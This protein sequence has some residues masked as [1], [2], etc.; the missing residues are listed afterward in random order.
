L[1]LHENTLLQNQALTKIQ[2]QLDLSN[3]ES[4]EKLRSLYELSP[5]GIALTDMNGHYIEFNE[6]FRR[7]CGYPEDELKVLDYW[8][9]TPKQYE[10]EEWCQLES[11]AKTGHYGPYEKEY[12]RKDG[13]RVP[14]CLNGLSV[15]GHD[16]KKYIW[17]IVE[18]ITERKLAETQVNQRAEMALHASLI[19]YHLLFE[20][21]RDAL[22]MLDPVSLKFTEANQATLDM[23]RVPSIAEF[24]KLGPP[25]V[26]P[27]RQPDDQLS[28]PQAKKIIESVLQE[29][30]R[31]F[32]W[33][34]QRTDGELF[35]ADVMLTRMEDEGKVFLMATVRDITERKQTETALQKEKDEQTLL[36]NKLEEVQ[37]H[38]M[39]SEK[40]ASIGLLAAGV[41]HEINNP[42]GY[43]YS[44]LGTLEKYAQDA[45]GLLALYEQA[46]DSISDAQVCESLKKAK[47]KLDIAFLKEDLSALIAESRNGITRVKDIVQN[48]KDFSHVDAA[49]VW[50]FSDLHRGM[51]S[52]LNIVNN[53]IKYKAD[54]V[55]EYGVIPEVECIS[56]Q[57]NQVFMNIL[58]NAAHA[59]DQHGTITIRTGQED[60]NIWVEI[61]DTG[62]GIAPEHLSKIFDPF[63][64]T[65]PVGKGTGLGLSLSYGIIQKHHGRIEVTSEVGKGTR[66]RVWLPIHQPQNENA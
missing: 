35:I 47:K 16:G 29:G 64:T 48:L 10:T 7:I 6:S 42:I 1:S 59:I 53:E 32:E 57:I 23:F 9:L 41:A 18:D 2:S 36:I 26:S 61:I 34:H 56:S 31:F 4:E 55:R 25:D 3:K 20:S 49:E 37:N 39:Q 24:A 13:T 50:H 40:M 62:K 33:V 43:V 65:K 5:L 30:S 17:S 12:V 28:G 44:N 66:F 14:L 51:E 54:L 27:L 11:L 52:T 63:F 46:E 21:S 58:V 15:T 8:K 22:M 38:L 45:L 60:D 19:K